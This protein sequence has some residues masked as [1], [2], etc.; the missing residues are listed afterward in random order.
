MILQELARL[1][2][3]RSR[4]PDPARRL[5]SPGFEDKEI[6]FVVE[7]KPDGSVVNVR[8]TRTQDG[9]RL[10]GRICLVPQGV[11]RAYGVAANLLWDTAEYALGI[12]G[13]GKPERLREQQDRTRGWIFEKSMIRLRPR[14]PVDSLLLACRDDLRRSA[15]PQF[16]L[17]S[18]QTP[19]D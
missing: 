1:Y 8:D 17:R 2:D 19:L 4:D 14:E 9:K 7:L 13:K 5:P 15:R 11:K 6:P 18:R 10:R 3:R 12:S 16:F